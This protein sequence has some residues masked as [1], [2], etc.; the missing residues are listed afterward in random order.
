MEIK[1]N[2][3]WEMAADISN[4]GE[5]MKW[6]HAEHFPQ[7]T[8]DY[9]VPQH[10]DSRV[11]D[12]AENV[13][14]KHTFSIDELNATSKYKLVFYGADRAKVWLNGVYAG[15]LERTLSKQVIE[16]NSLK[17]GNNTLIIK[18]T[19]IC[20]WTIGLSKS[21]FIMQD[22]DVAALHQKMVH[23][24]PR[25]V[26][27]AQV[28][29]VFVRNFSE[30]GDLQSVYEKLEYIRD[31]GT[32]VLWFMPIHPIGQIGRKGT[33]G[34]PYAI[35][36]YYEIDP[37]YGTHEEFKKIVEQA[38]KLGMKVI[39]DLVINHTAKD[40]VMSEIDPRYYKP[41]HRQVADLWG[42]TDVT[43]LDY[44]YPPTREYIKN[45]MAWWIS[46]YDIDGYRCDVAFLVPDEFWK[47]AIDYIRSIKAEIM[48]LA[49]SDVPEQ[50]LAGF[51]LTYDWH[52]MG[53]IQRIGQGYY[54]VQE[55]ENYI[56]AMN[57]YFPENALRILF[58]ENHD[59]DRAASKIPGE[60]L[61]PLQVLKMLAPGVPM[62]YNGEENAIA[63][64]PD[65]F[66]KD[67]I[68]WKDT[69]P[70]LY[71]TLQFLGR[72]RQSTSALH[73]HGP[74][75]VHIS[76]DRDSITLE[77]KNSSSTLL[78]NMDSKIQEYTLILDGKEV[79]NSDVS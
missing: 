68:D 79:L 54:P 23:T 38:H 41:S 47:E 34:S 9:W 3:M 31:L 21:V 35:S 2:G 36:D 52:F 13:W 44:S 27:K 58:L 49:E 16:V 19:D 78:F 75:T 18:F 33:Y 66:E 14:L 59:F 77:R 60:K 50:H 56:T 39:M 20:E 71:K 76:S 73:H 42:W 46:E 4:I 17:P 24:S 10:Q 11:L 28:Y 74:E 64:K 51:D 69:N 8:Q 53:L 22:T 5:E 67:A 32:T 48:M 40:N 65:L 61:I 43:D 63:H 29:C 30:K 72:L 26:E 15:L 7:D 25:W 12:L 45:M 70:D 62:L 57:E 37:D 1:L 55:L 6:Y